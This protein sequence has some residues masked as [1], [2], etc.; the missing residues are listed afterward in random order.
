MGPLKFMSISERR[1]NG[2][3]TFI[4]KSNLEN[5]P[6]HII[7]AFNLTSLNFNGHLTIDLLFIQ[8]NSE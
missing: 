5:Q 4:D 2:K 1:A 3:G 6:P 7:L 8:S